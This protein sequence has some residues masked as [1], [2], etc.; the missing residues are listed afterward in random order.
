MIRARS[1]PCAPQPTEMT[2]V[3]ADL[4]SIR[5]VLFD[6]Y[7]TLFVSG[8]GDIGVSMAAGAHT[9]FARTLFSVAPNLLAGDVRPGLQWSEAE[10]DR[11]TVEENGEAE[12]GEAIEAYRR[13]GKAARTA[14]YGAIEAFHREK[15]R[16]GIDYPE[17]DIREVWARV[18]SDLYE[19]DLLRDL[20][21]PEVIE[22][23]AV[24]YELRSNPVW[25]MPQA[26]ETL[27]NLNEAG[28]AL[29]VVSNA[30]FFTPL[31]FP[32]LLGREPGSLGLQQRLSAYSYREGRAKPSPQMFS[33]PL[34]ELR[35]SYDIRPEQ[36]LYVG[37]DMKND[38]MTASRAG[39]RACLFAG[40]RRSLRAREDDEEASRTRPD[41]VILELR[42]LGSMLS[43]GGAQYAKISD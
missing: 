26:D 31:L 42:E 9:Q 28:Y 19:A 12:N 34:S 43:F 36:V 8:S 15:R 16:A 22:T 11:P 38:M 4:S 30:Q 13:V 10:R 25:P 32:A 39:C 24:D 37:N 41:A 3:H 7:G 21:H 27:R 5:A 33:S 35:R 23:I 2:P 6:I 1:A 29:G 14:Y 40:D 20:P 18:F 17:V